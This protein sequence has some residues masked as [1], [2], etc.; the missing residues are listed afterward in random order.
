MTAKTPK[1]KSC[2]AALNYRADDGYSSKTTFASVRQKPNMF[3]KPDPR[4]CWIE[5]ADELARVAELFDFGDRVEAAVK[6]ARKR[7]K[8]WRKSGANS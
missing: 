4:E 5:V 2:S 6:D 3:A 1:M 8:E 7:V